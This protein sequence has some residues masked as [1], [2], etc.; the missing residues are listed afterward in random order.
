MKLPADNTAYVS[1]ITGEQPIF[2]APA[3]TTAHQFARPPKVGDIFM[4]RPDGKSWVRTN[5]VA[6]LEHW[7]PLP[8]R[9]VVTSFSA[10]AGSTVPVPDNDPNTHVFAEPPNPGDIYVVHNEDGRSQTWIAIQG[11]GGQPVFWQHTASLPP[12]YTMSMVAGETPDAPGTTTMP[13]DTDI[14]DMFVNPTDGLMWTAVSDG[15]GGTR[16]MDVGSRPGVTVSIIP[17]ELPTA[18][19]TAPRLNDEFIN[20]AD[21]LAWVYADDDG[22][23]SPD[24]VPVADAAATRPDV[25]VNDVAG[26]TPTSLHT[27]GPPIPE[28]GTW[29]CRNDR[30]HQGQTAAPGEFTEAIVTTYSLHPID[31]QGTDHTAFFQNLGQHD[32][33]TFTAAGTPYRYDAADAQLVAGTVHFRGQGGTTYVPMDGD[34]IT[35]LAKQEPVTLVGQRD[36]VFINRVDGHTWIYADDDGTGSP[37]WVQLPSPSERP[38]VTVSD[39]AGDTPT[40]DPTTQRDD[41][42]INTVDEMTWIYADNDG[43]GN[44]GWVE[45][46]QQIPDALQVLHVKGAAASQPDDIRYADLFDLTRFKVGQWARVEMSDVITTV[47]AGQHI[48]ITNHEGV[49]YTATLPYTVPV[50]SWIERWPNNIS[51][52]PPPEMRP[53]VTVSD[54]P[55]DTADTHLVPLGTWNVEPHSTAVTAGAVE[56]RGGSPYVLIMTAADGAGT[57][58]STTFA[59]VNVGDTVHVRDATGQNGL[60]IVATVVNHTHNPAPGN[61]DLLLINGNETVVGTLP[62]DG[63]AVQ[64]TFPAANAPAK[65]DDVFINTHDDKTW[66]YADDDGSGTPGWVRMGGAVVTTVSNPGETPT[67]TTVLSTPDAG[68]VFINTQDQMTWIYDGEN[69]QWIPMGAAAVS[70]LN[71]LGIVAAPNPDYEVGSW[72]MDNSLANGKF[73]ISQRPP[74]DLTLMPYD[75]NGVNQ[76]IDIMNMNIGPG[77]KIVM[78]SLSD[79]DVRIM[80]DVQSLGVRTPGSAFVFT[81]HIETSWQVAAL[82]LPAR[83]GSGWR[84]T[85][86]TRRHGP[87]SRYELQHGQLTPGGYLMVDHIHQGGNPALPG[88]PAA[89]PMNV[90]DWLVAL[91]SD[92]DGTSDR[93]HLVRH[94]KPP[95]PGLTIGEIKMW[96]TTT[97]PADHLMCDGSTIQRR[98]VPRSAPVAR[99][100][101]P[102]RHARSVRAWL[103]PE[104]GNKGGIKTKHRVADCSTTQ[105]RSSPTSRAATGTTI[106]QLRV[107]G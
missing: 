79:P 33:V 106:D 87:T 53:D 96:P 85:S 88:I 83:C 17:G 24:W 45:L 18:A 77:D 104:T 26:D 19:V 14:G 25:T 78:Q 29:T 73:T 8:T 46:P 2:P 34:V 28:T 82:R 65:R 67:T 44:P 50:G 99:H 7:I 15:A 72:T 52:W 80:C 48:D 51:I 37:G 97:P 55:G 40:T 74:G 70:G 90:G 60:D 54:I 36:D 86:R 63:T 47:P 62:P 10:A 42:F 4:N 23:G 56:F 49:T 22:N 30:T 102:A 20:T 32:I 64:I 59:Q 75:A 92:G 98:D 95:V 69:G 94:D 13:A 11:F 16:W 5:D 61:E 107:V 31:E 93:F 3:G 12:Q 101:R 91:D 103:Q 6:G 105:Q 43:T 9:P 35:N 66:I 27:Y 76:E 1:D 41:V 89:T 68:D 81:G 84:S 57:D 39:A 71:L 58:H 100:Q 21:H 38:A